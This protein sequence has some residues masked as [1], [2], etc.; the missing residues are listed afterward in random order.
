[1]NTFNIVVDY[2]DTVIDVTIDSSICTEADVLDECKRCYED[3]LATEEREAG[4]GDPEKFEVSDW[5]D[6]PEWAQDFDILEELMPEYED[7]SYDIEVFE[8]AWECDV[9]FSDVDEAYQGEW[10]DEEEFAQNLLE[11]CGD[12]PKDLP[13]YV[14][15]DWN[16][17]AGHIM[18]DYNEHNGHY[19]RNI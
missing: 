10:E 19:F 12:I 14:E 16:A 17:T 7:S 6:V 15:I 11:E 2:M 13:W 1:M 18:A 8:A 9:Q 4:E 5:C 3:L